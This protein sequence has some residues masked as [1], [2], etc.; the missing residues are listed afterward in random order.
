MRRVSALDEVEIT[1]RDVRR[2][3]RAY[4]GNISYLDEWT[5]RLMST[6]SS[7]GVA[8]DT[9]VVVLADHGDM[10]GERGLWYKMSFFEDSAR[11]PLIGAMLVGTLPYFLADEWLTR[12]AGAP[13]GATPWAASAWRLPPAR[14]PARS[15]RS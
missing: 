12:G 4:Y 3:R 11:V 9:V 7:L 8:E 1:P 2:A 5:A 14:P 6:M 15:S 13:R 10:L